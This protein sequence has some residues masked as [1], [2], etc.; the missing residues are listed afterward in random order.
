MYVDLADLKAYLRIPADDETDDVELAAAIA[1][2][3]SEIDHL[4]SQSFDVATPGPPEDR[5]AWYDTPE[6]DETE[7][8]YV[9]QVPALTGPGVGGLE[10]FAWNETEQGYTTPVALAGDPYRPRN[11]TP[12]PRPWTALV[13]GSGYPD[14]QAVL[15]QAF[16]GWAEV[17]AAVKTAVMIQASRIFKRR[18]SLFGMVNT[19]DGS[20]QARLTRVVDPDV[21][22][23]LRGY[24]KYWGAR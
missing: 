7:R 14:G 12:S 1:T 13:L 8:A 23:A 10:V 3:C 17:P 6:W 16:F 5:G 4:C 15:I 22:V 19:L 2:A 21:V 24:I 20:E 9:V 11:G 18:D